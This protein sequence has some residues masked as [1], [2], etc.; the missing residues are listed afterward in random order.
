MAVRRWLCT[1]TKAALPGNWLAFHF[2]WRQCCVM[3]G[4]MPGS[5]SYFELIRSV[6]RIIGISSVRLVP[7]IR[8][9]IYYSR[10]EYIRAK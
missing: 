3:N 4:A 8:G 7:P 5:W 6:S 9:K 10:S 1:L 2:G